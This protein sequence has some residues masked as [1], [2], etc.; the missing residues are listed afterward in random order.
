LLGLYFNNTNLTGR[1]VAATNATID[2]D[3]GTN[4]PRNGIAPDLFSVRWTGRIRAPQ[5]APYTF[6]LETDDGVRFW[7]NHV[8]LIDQWRDGTCAADSQPVPLVAGK[9][10]PVCMEMYENRVNAKARLFWNAPNQ[11][12][13]LLP[14]QYLFPDAPPGSQPAI[15]ENS[16]GVLLRDGSF[17][18]LTVHSG[19]ESTVRFS[20]APA[21]PAVAATDVAQIFFQ[22]LPANLASRLEPGRR[23]LLLRNGD[24][25]DGA[26]RE[27]KQNQIKLSSVLFGLKSYPRD[28]A[29]V[30][31]LHDPVASSARFEIRARNG[32]RFLANDLM[33][34]KDQIRLRSSPLAG[35]V[36]AAKDLVELRRCSP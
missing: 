26:L 5:T 19:D 30:L 25:V 33:F 10:Y 36:V 28:Q 34:E 14:T 3:W 7:L 24:F 9:E 22:S 4:P 35:W 29:L 8:L 6:H 13:A 31:A 1:F 32:S 20:A 15:T 2:F 11:P 21:D 16:S 23:G 27:F 12:R 17:L 18:A